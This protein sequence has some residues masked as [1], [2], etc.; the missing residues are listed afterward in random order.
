M[1]NEISRPEGANMDA[2]I[3][4][5]PRI[6][7]SIREGNRSKVAS[8]LN[9]F[10]EMVDLQVPGFGSWIHYASAHGNLEIVKYLVSLGSDLNVRDN[11]MN[12]RL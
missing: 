9:E 2:E 4:P 11:T 6:T 8:L 10:P 12:K 3:K 5:Y 1:S 7:A